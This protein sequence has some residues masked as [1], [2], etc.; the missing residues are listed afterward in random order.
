VRTGLVLGL[1][2]PAR[3]AALAESLGYDFA[4]AGEHVFFRSPATNAF[5][6]L[7][8]A[9]AA[10]SRIRLL[11]SV[12][13]LP[14]YPVG[15]AAKL[16]AALDRVSGGR[17]ELG[18]GIGGEFPEEFE[19]CGVD[20]RQRGR[21]TDE[22]LTV[23]LPLLRGETVTHDGQFARLQG[24]ALAPPPVQASIRVWVAGRREPAQRR[25]ARFGDVW[26]PYMCTPEM[27]AD[28]LGRIRS[29]AEEL[30]RG[31]AVAGALFAWLDVD[32]DGDLAR[33]NVVAAASATYRQ[34]FAPLA[35]RYLIA[36]TP[37]EVRARL[38]EFRDA[39]VETAIVGLAAPG[40]RREHAL[41]LLADEVFPR[42]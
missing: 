27:V 15:L 1:D 22:A 34:D 12:T 8:A 29:I 6:A 18:V 42:L 9:A 19:A 23:L 10:T 21:R 14:L 30:G 31:D 41:R 32:E 20:V 5:V 28:G 36:G 2:T 35:S 13:L 39:G 7:G 37:D 4:A 33:S 16:A 40:K 26:L 24:L 38:A 11:S 17:F 3:D 25:A